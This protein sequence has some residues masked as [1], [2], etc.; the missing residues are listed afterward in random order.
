MTWQEIIA[1][2]LLVLGVGI[3]LLCCVGIVAMRRTFDRLHYVGPATVLGPVLIA[4]SVVCTEALSQAGIKAILIALV[5]MIGGPI[6][7]HATGRAARLRQYGNLDVQPGD[8]QDS[9]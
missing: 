2:V 1:R 8:R 7:T 3:E 4:A 9:L 5:L 6:V